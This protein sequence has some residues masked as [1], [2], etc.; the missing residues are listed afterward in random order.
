MKRAPK[1]KREIPGINAPGLLDYLTTLSARAEERVK[2][3]I[4]ETL[5]AVAK[6]T[7][8]MILNGDVQPPKNGEG[9]ALYETGA[10]AEAIGVY[11]MPGGK[12]KYVGLPPT[13]THG[14]SGLTWVQIYKI[15][16]YGT[17]TVP[18]RPHLE[19]AA[20]RVLADL[21]ASL[22]KAGFSRVRRR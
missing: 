15:L 5:E 1:G 22:K 4:D 18:A 7:R 17:E 20:S 12:E 8:E 14:P 9:I 6:R 21:S 13:G 10:Y 19:V 2:S 11:T 16:T 3:V